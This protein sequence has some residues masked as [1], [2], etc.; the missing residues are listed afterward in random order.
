M[1]DAEARRKGIGGSDMAHMLQLPPYGCMHRLWREKRGMGEQTPV[2]GAM[3]RGIRGEEIAAEEYSRETGRKVWRR[4]HQQGDNPWE[5]GN[6]DRHIVAFDERGPGVLEVKCPGQWMFRTMKREGL[7]EAYIAQLQWYMH[8]TGWRWGSYAIFHLD[9]WELLW[10]DVERDDALI[11]MLRDRAE[12]A[13]VMVENGPAPERLAANSAT[14]ARC[15]HRGECHGEEAMPAWAGTIEQ[16]PELAPL[17][18]E[19][20]EARQIES[21]AADYKAEVGERIKTALGE[22][23][24]VETGA[25]RIYHC[26]QSRTTVDTKALRARYPDVAREVE[27]TTQFRS[28]RV[29]PRKG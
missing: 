3:Q 17:L 1:I 18:D 16:A 22:R 11:A 21:D 15:H 23:Q 2:T 26:A 13:W 12:R 10:W 28:L 14:C 7:A 8:V 6:L 24:V 19:Y 29:F 20:D 5:L 4:A 27:R 9:S 25:G